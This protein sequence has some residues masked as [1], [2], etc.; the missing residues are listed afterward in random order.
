M[1]N[2]DYKFYI[3]QTL[4][5]PD[6]LKKFR[7]MPL[8]EI[9]IEKA[10][11]WLKDLEKNYSDYKFVWK[12][13]SYMYT[14]P[15]S[16]FH[17][18]NGEVG[19]C[20]MPDQWYYN[21]C[22]QDPYKRGPIPNELRAYVKDEWKDDPDSNELNPREGFR[23]YIREIID[24]LADTGIHSKHWCVSGMTPGSMLT[25]H[26]DSDYNL[27]L[28]IPLYADDSC[29]WTIDDQEYTFRPGYAYLINTSLF[30]S[31]DNSKGNFTRIHVYGKLFTEEC[32]KKWDLLTDS[33]NA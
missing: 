20:L 19:H 33:D 22:F 15:P 1:G 6:T 5:I 28:H 18:P 2:K 4:D 24:N 8:F 10:R 3:Q 23:G 26:K 14:R 21:L 31:V 30:H 29:V 17:D 27:R 25:R 11:A 9:D 32:I 16:D 12:D 7:T 13:H